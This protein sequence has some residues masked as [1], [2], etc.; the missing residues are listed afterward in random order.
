MLKD[1]FDILGRS[2]KFVKSGSPASQN[3]QWQSAG[4][5]LKGKLYIILSVF[6]IY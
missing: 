1:R 3:N 5:K 4:K 2:C 6:I